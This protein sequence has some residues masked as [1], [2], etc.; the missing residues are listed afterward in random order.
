MAKSRLGLNP[1]DLDTF[2]ANLAAIEERLSDSERLIRARQRVEAILFLSREPLSPRKIAQLA[3]LADATQARTLTR[4]LNEM[5]RQENQAFQIEE[6]SGGYI[7]LTRPQFSRWLRRLEHIPGEV[8]LGLPALE[9]LTIIAYRQPVVRAYIEAVRGANC[10][11][12][13]KQLLERDLIRIAGRSEELGR[14]YLYGTTKRFLQVF[15]LRSLEHLPRKNGFC[16]MDSSLQILRW[17]IAFTELN[18]TQTIKPNFKHKGRSRRS[19][20]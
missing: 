10:D 18:Q 13:L 5:Y 11:E 7:L 1:V 19:P 20:L 17:T 6:T 12:A 8:R 9:T 15:G 3:C 2:R 4:Q 16:K 14:P